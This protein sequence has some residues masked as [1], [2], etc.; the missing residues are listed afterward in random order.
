[1]STEPKTPERA[2]FHQMKDGTQEDW[3]IIGRHF[4]PLAAG[5]PDRAL[6]HL[7]LLAGDHGGFA[8]DRLTHS[9]QT[10]TLA[11]E[12]GRDEDYVVCALLHDIGD[13]L[14]PINHPEIGAAMVR[15]Y[16]SEKLHWIVEH[17][18]IFQGY[19]FWHHV[20][21]DRDAREAFRD[22]EW[23]DACAEFCE[24]YDQAA[25]DPHGKTL[26]LEAFEPI[27]R[28]VLAPPPTAIPSPSTAE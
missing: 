11:L 22:H 7:G 5:L 21:M 23:F 20:G 18:G 2:A 14:A 3:A 19:Y 24:L 6:A 9:L 27:L 8:V 13:V 17:H 4:R 12:D 28:R 26:P 25:F 16:V 15:P 10:A 1:M